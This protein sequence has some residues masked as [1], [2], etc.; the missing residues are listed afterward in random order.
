MNCQKPS[1]KEQPKRNENGEFVCEHCSYRTPKKSHLKRHV[2]CVHDKTFQISKPF[3]Y[4]PTDDVIVP[5]R[6]EIGMF[7]CQHCEYSA[8][9]RSH[10]RRHLSSIHRAVFRNENGEIMYVDRR[11]WQER[12][13]VTSLNR[14]RQIPFHQNSP[15]ILPSHHQNHN[16][17]QLPMVMDC[18]ITEIES[19]ESAKEPKL[20]NDFNISL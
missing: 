16:M 20:D 18:P 13:G 2:E 3:E 4:L 6:N 10:L 7:Q 8:K 9:Q 5:N 19:V 17:N 15:S 14:K 1:T 12:R 11:T